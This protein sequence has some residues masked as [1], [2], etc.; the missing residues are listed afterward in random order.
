MS[1]TLS[2]Y[3][4]AR[5]ENI[6]KNE[7]F[8][9]SLGLYKDPLEVAKKEAGEELRRKAEKIKKRAARDDDGEEYVPVRRSSRKPADAANK[10]EGLVSL[11]DVEG[12]GT[13]RVKRKY[14]PQEDAE[15]FFKIKTQYADEDDDAMSIRITPEQLRTYVQGANVKHSEMIS[16]KVGRYQYIP[17]TFQLFLFYIQVHC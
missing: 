9:K 10:E 6:K 12:G 16:D 15:Q 8:L 3:E 14:N 4:L 5:L 17:Y 7:E 2:D 1:N 11:S 13:A